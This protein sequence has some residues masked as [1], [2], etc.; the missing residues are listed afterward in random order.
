MLDVVI[1]DG[2]V[3]CGQLSDCRRC[4]LSRTLKFK[5]STC[6]AQ[7]PFKFRIQLIDFTRVGSGYA[8][9]SLKMFL[10]FLIFF[11]VSVL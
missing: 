11:L 3:R 9:R 4:S 1:D 8:L 10:S 7:V 2:I 5:S 6:F